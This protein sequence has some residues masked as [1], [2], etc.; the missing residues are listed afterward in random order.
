MNITEHLA[1]RA[2]T[3]WQ[4]LTINYPL[5]TM[6][7]QSMSGS[8]KK[9]LVCF[10]IKCKSSLESHLMTDMTVNISMHSIGSIIPS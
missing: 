4:P 7:T 9:K 1:L 8:H 2:D 6:N 3:V 5:F 10:A